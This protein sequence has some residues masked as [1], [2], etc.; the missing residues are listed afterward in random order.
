MPRQCPFA[1]AEAAL[2]MT[3]LCAFPVFST[4]LLQPCSTLPS[5]HLV[6]SRNAAFQLAL[7]FLMVTINFRGQYGYG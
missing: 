4:A 3:A 6:G 5:T 2:R 1:Q 7:E